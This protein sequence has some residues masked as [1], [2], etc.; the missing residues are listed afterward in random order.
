MKKGI[1]LSGLDMKKFVGPGYY[2]KTNITNT[3]G[4]DYGRTRNDE[5][6]GFKSQKKQAGTEPKERPEVYY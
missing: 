4:R 2:P 5:I 6:E 1:D 3:N